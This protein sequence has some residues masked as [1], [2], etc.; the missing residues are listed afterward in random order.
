VREASLARVLGNVL[1]RANAQAEV[2]TPSATGTDFEGLSLLLVDDNEINR[3]VGTRML[4]KLGATAKLAV[5]GAEAVRLV[6][7]GDYDIVF[8]DCQ[9]PEMDGFEAT[10]AV[11]ER[12]AQQGGHVRIV[13]MTA[14]AMEGDRERCLAC[15]MD[16]Y[17]SKPVK[18]EALLEQLRAALANKLDRAA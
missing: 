8:M 17:V 2:A 3:K 4:Q 9:M 12:E 5:N 15:G 6:A 13:A 7:E 18:L 14:N 11:R 16:D 10:R 1:G